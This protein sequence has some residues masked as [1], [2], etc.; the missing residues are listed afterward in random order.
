MF[1]GC[2]NIRKANAGSVP[3]VREAGSPILPFFCKGW[4]CTSAPMPSLSLSAKPRPLIATHCALSR[5]HLAFTLDVMS[6]YLGYEIALLAVILFV[7]FA[8]LIIRGRVSR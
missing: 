5:N 1:A 2:P 6:Y 7:G 3:H 4:D 8:V